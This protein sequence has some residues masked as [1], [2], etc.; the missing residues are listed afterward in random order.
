MI[1]TQFLNRHVPWHKFKYVQM[2]VL[3]QSIT[4]PRS[5]SCEPKTRLI[6]RVPFSGEDRR[7]ARALPTNFLQTTTRPW[8]IHS[9][10]FDVIVPNPSL[11]IG[12][13]CFPRSD[14][15]PVLAMPP[16]KL[17][18]EI[19]GTSHKWGVGQNFSVSTFEVF[20]NRDLSIQCSPPTP[21]LD[22]GDPCRVEQ[23]TCKS[24]TDVFRSFVLLES[25]RKVPCSYNR[26]LMHLVFLHLEAVDKLSPRS[27]RFSRNGIRVA[28]SIFVEWRIIFN[29]FCFISRLANFCFILSQT[30]LLNLC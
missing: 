15:Y 12:Q 25:D 22:K 6:S 19:S 27:S 5:F 1:H 21:H 17:G 18:S 8:A 9:F 14:M 26:T 7:H 13:P 30:T 24:C 29:G 23:S 28:A 10:T 11:H 3:D 16:S 2:H 20:E 4:V